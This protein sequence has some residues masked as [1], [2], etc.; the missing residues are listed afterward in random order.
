MLLSFRVFYHERV[1]AIDRASTDR[2]NVDMQRRK[3][4][5]RID[6]VSFAVRTPMAR[7]VR[8][9]PVFTAIMFTVDFPSTS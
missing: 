8:E 4:P 2:R 5:L 6:S 7:N 1:A 3:Y 9:Q